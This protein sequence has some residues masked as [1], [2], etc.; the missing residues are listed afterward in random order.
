MTPPAFGIGPLTH[1]E[2]LDLDHLPEHLIVLG[3][4]YVGLELPRPS[5][6][7]VAA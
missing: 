2:A 7:S 3:G 1:V 5:A 6:A 4:G